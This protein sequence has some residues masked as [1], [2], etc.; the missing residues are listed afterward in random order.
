MPAVRSDVPLH[1]GLQ[2]L[3]TYVVKF[4]SPLNQHLG[5]I[6]SH[7]D[8]QCCPPASE[9]KDRMG[10]GEPNPEWEELAENTGLDLDQVQLYC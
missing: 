9:T 3:R 4:I 5:A 1:W 7:K 2:H 10:E 6:H 8:F